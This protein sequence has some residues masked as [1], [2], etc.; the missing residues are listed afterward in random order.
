ME[1]MEIDFTMAQ[2]VGNVIKGK[3]GR[4]A[5]GKGK[6]TP[7]KEEKPLSEII[8]DRMHKKPNLKHIGTRLKTEPEQKYQGRKLRDDKIVEAAKQAVEARVAKHNSDVIV[9]YYTPRNVPGGYIYMGGFLVKVLKDETRII[10]PK[11]VTG[12]HLMNWR[13]AY[14][15]KLIAMKNEV[16]REN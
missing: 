15:D 6:S 4:K 5:K 7:A 11:G 13:I 14:E 3:P 10:L 8:M 2:N 1:N 12:E 9:H 16:R